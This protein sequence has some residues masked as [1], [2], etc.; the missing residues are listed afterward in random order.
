MIYQTNE[1]HTAWGDP[2][3]DPGY[4][5]T[6]TCDDNSDKVMNSSMNPE[7]PCDG[8]NYFWHGSNIKAPTSW[9]WYYCRNNQKCIHIDGRCDLHPNPACIYEKDGIMVAEDEEGCFENYKWKGLLA[10][11]AN[12]ICSS[13]DHNKLSPAVI[14]TIYSGLHGMFLEWE[15]KQKVF[16]PSDNVF[17]VYIIRAANPANLTAIFCLV[18]VCP[19]KAIVGIK[20]LA[21]FYSPLFKTFCCILPL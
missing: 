9:G 8:S 13:S 6:P 20:F 16:S 15:I 2:Q 17:H 4:D 19:Q 21:Y 11:S 7:N 10:K 12:V 14:S 18:L 5:I 3:E 1:F